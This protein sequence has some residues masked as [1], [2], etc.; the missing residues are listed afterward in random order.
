MADTEGDQK[1][2]ATALEPQMAQSGRRVSVV[3]GGGIVRQ[4]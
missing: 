4:A 3:V 2:N 1:V